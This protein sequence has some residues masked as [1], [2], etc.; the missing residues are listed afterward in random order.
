M[1]KT[2][3]KEK[4]LEELATLPEQMKE[5]NQKNALFTQIYEYLANPVGQDRLDVY[6]HGSKVSN[7]L[8]YKDNKLWV[9]KNL[10]LDVI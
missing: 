4:K 2:K 10:R 3:Q 9:D 8:L 6:L 5:S 7:G 1:L